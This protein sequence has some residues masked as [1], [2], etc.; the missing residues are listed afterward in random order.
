M[1]KSLVGI[2]Q[3]DPTQCRRPKWIVD[4]HCDHWDQDCRRLDAVALC[5]QCRQG[6]LWVNMNFKKATWQIK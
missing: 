4:T 5:D 1:L 2:A 3:Q 6:A